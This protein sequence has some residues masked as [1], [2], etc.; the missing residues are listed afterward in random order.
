LKS[1]A[2]PREAQQVANINSLAEGLG[3]TGPTELQ[4]VSA[5]EPKPFPIVI[6]EWDRNAG[7]VVR[8]ALDLYKGRH[9]INVRVWYRD[10]G[11]VKPSKSGITLAVRH[12]PAV[13]DALA[14]ALLAAHDT[15]LL[16]DGDER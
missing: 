6:A 5:A 9:T 16:N 13:A 11:E 8:V 2:L 1:L 15:G 4:C 12:L 10:G 7:E 3:K 14:N